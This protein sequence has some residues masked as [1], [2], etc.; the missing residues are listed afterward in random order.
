M[1]KSTDMSHTLDQDKIYLLF[2][3][4]KEMNLLIFMII[5][6]KVK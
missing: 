1:I 2:L 6:R 4:I 5:K 3:C